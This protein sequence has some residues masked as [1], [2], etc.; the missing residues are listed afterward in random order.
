M[1]N[2]TITPDSKSHSLTSKYRKSGKKFC[3]W[4]YPYYN[5]YYSMQQCNLTS[6][7]L[8]TVCLRM[9]VENGSVNFPNHCFSI[10]W[11]TVVALFLSSSSIS[12]TTSSNKLIWMLLV[13]ICSLVGEKSLSGGLEMKEN[14]QYNPYYRAKFLRGLHGLHCSCICIQ[15][16]ICIL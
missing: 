5:K 4:V 13:I 15:I 7:K 16:L 14:K 12:T 8:Q 2:K 1:D 10:L 6:I 9:R 11:W 3:G